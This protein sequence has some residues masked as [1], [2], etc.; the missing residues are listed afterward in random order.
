MIF[1]RLELE[2]KI[3]ILEVELIL[4]QA[5]NDDL[6]KQI[7]EDAESMHKLEKEFRELFGE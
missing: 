2:Q 4:R 3:F 6:K 7:E 5:H 1:L